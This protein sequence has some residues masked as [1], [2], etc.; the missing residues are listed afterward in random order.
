V[1]DFLDHYG[2]IALTIGTFL[3]GETA[4]LVASSLIHKGFFE[5]PYTVFFGF[6]GSF[7]SDWLYYM[8]G[9]L[10]GKYFVEKRPKLKVKVAPVQRFFQHHKLQILIS[11]RF[12]YGFRVII[13]LIVGMSSIKPIQYLI[14]SIISGLIWATTI[15]TVGYAVGRFLNVKTSV[16]EKNIVFIVIGFAIFGML[17]GYIVKRLA[18]KKMSA[19]D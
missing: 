18:F 19:E 4:I 10:N 2:Y 14:Y 13:P 5:G 11:Y 15:S 3:E 17:M 12:L 16:F 7:I 9:R 1:E 6:A 8:I